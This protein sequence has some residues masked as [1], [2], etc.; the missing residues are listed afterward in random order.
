[1]NEKR[2]VE[3]F[4]KYVTIDSESYSEKEFAM[5]LANDFKK[6]GCDISFDNA[7]EKIGGDIGNLYCT[8]KGNESK[9]PIL[10]SAHMDTVKPGKGIKPI[11]DNGIIKSSGD[12][13]L[14]ADDKAGVSVIIELLR[15][16]KEEKI[17]FP[18]IEVVFTVAE[19]MGLKGASNLDY[20]RIKSKKGIILDDGGEAGKIIYSAP[21]HVVLEG[22]F[23]GKSSHAGAAPE[24]GKSSV[25]MACEAISKM[26]LQRIDEET[27]ANISGMYSD[28]ATNIIPEKTKILGEARST[29]QKK[30]KNQMDHMMQCI[31]D[32]CEKYEGEFQ[33][34]FQ[35][36]YKGYKYETNGSFIQKLKEACEN[37]GVS[38]KLC[39]SGGGSDANIISS[40]GIQVINF[41]CGME[42][43]HGL[44]EQVS[45]NELKKVVNI[46]VEFVKIN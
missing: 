40:N 39:V 14:G 15:T 11:I 38:P 7:G 29:D 44:E 25:R 9:E 41:S 18:T 26:K 5:V 17:D 8:L 28:Y 34:G 22:V 24:A 33:G 45:I 46:L 16:I 23:T 6:L 43:V 35:E 36:T 37:V 27:T 30:L 2:L 31:K 21:G 12:T 1:M 20:S 32:S 10:F 4:L 13:I 19:E 3:T 42:K